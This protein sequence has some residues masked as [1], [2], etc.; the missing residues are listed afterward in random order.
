MANVLFLSTL[1]FMTASLQDV[2]SRVA[3]AYGTCLSYRDEGVVT[4]TFFR[5]GKHTQRKLFSTRFLRGQGILFEFRTRR[6]EDDWDQYALWGEISRANTWWS[7]MPDREKGISLESAIAG[8]TGVSGGA[9]YRTPKLLMPELGASWLDRASTS[10]TVLIVPEAT[11][12]SCVVIE[13]PPNLGEPEQVWIDT[14]TFLIRR[15]VNQRHFLGSA[16]DEA[17]E[18]LTTLDPEHAA[19]ITDRIREISKRGV[20]VESTI[21]Y[22][23]VFNANVDPT[24]LIFVP[25]A[26]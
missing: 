13:C 16:S 26:T 2:I 7:I 6:G 12:L 9:A 10:G 3:A 25:P 18:H 15:I 19:E 8:A 17:I 4:T 14:S 20:E 11:T 21:N 24:E 22:D 23:A 5:P 1:E